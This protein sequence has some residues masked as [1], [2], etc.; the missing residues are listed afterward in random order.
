M[1]ANYII[2]TPARDEEAFLEFTAASVAGQ[3]VSP[4]EWVVVDDG[5]SDR[6]AELIGRWARQHEWITPVY[7]PSSGPRVNGFGPMRAFRAGLQALRHKDWDFLVKLDADLGF[8]FD[9]FATCF[10][11]FAADARLGITGGQIATETSKGDTVERQPGFHVRGATKIY[12][13]ECWDAIDGL[14]DGPGWDTVDE[15]T[16]NM[17]GWR[18]RTLQHLTVRQYRRTGGA[19]G[20]FRDAVKNGRANYVAAYHP[21]FMLAKCCRRALQFPYVL[22]S[23]ALLHGYFQGYVRRQPRVNDPALISYVR[24]QQLRRLVGLTSIWQ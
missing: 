22:H 7:L 3:C 16:A 13:R 6:T 2:I 10:D 19:A 9:Y 21:L 12:R 1:F 5:S 8:S 17:L 14:I 11:E 20:W 23:A 15:L 18:T 24:H 4:R